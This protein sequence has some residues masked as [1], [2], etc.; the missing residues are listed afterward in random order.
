MVTNTNMATL[1][2]CDFWQENTTRTHY[3]QC[4]A[5]R[6]LFNKVKYIV[7]IIYSIHIRNN[8]M[9]WC[10][11]ANS[12]FQMKKTYAAFYKYSPHSADFAKS[13]T[14]ITATAPCCLSRGG[15]GDY[16]RDRSLAAPALCRL[17]YYN[18]SSMRRTNSRSSIVQQPAAFL[19]QLLPFHIKRKSN[20][21]V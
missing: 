11:S 2:M 7:S 1:T 4:S 13:L 15:L 8:T 3:K 5:C 18:D 12:I 10:K 6:R 19:N 21:K 14:W 20:N 16:H 9:T 17:Y